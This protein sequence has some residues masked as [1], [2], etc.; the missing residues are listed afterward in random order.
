MAEKIRKDPTNHAEKG[1]KNGG[2]ENAHSCL[3]RK[4]SKRDIQNETSFDPSSPRRQVMV[5]DSAFV[6]DGLA[7]SR[8][9]PLPQGFVW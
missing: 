3:V 8:A 5:A 9:S 7:L 6:L 2:R 1:D 4:N